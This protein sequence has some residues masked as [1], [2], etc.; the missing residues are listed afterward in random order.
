MLWAPKTLTGQHCFAGLVRT[1]LPLME[2]TGVTT[3]EEIDVMTSTRVLRVT[4]R[5]RSGYLHPCCLVLGRPFISR[6]SD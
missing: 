5:S 4:D 1:L 6:A 3:A 2:R